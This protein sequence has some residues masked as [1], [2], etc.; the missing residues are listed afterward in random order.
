M[1]SVHLII[2]GDVQGV[3][4][5]AWVKRKADNL[6]LTGWVKNRSDGTVE[7]VI[8]GEKALVEKMIAL[9]RQG[10]EVACVEDVLVE[11]LYLKAKFS[12]FEIRPTS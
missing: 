4:F 7:A 2:S 5:R 12:S 8:Q 1:K 6:G 10:P 9:C 3:G 11:N